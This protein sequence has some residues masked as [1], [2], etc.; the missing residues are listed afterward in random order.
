MS[1]TI[2]NNGANSVEKILSRFRFLLLRIR[3]LLTSVVI[4]QFF[5]INFGLKFSEFELYFDDN[6]FLFK[7][8]EILSRLQVLI[9][10]LM[11]IL[12]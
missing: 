12:R 9:V 2:V 4:I 7:I 5:K 1:T 11:D 8:K 6:E 3:Q 10:M